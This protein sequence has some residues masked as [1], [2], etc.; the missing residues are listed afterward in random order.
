MEKEAQ[1]IA[2]ESEAQSQEIR[3]AEKKP[4]FRVEPCDPQ[5]ARRK[6]LH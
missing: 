1:R 5:M 2:E 3:P 4:L 6:I